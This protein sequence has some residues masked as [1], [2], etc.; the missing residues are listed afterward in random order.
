[1]EYQNIC[2]KGIFFS[3]LAQMVIAKV[4]SDQCVKLWH[5]SAMCF[6]NSSVDK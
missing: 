5:N 2:I 3:F 1:M 4:L 6:E